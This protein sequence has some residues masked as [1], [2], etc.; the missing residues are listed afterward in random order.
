MHLEVMRKIT[1]T[2]VNLYRNRSRVATKSGT[3][4]SGLTTH[5][6]NKN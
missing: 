1:V 5:P 6:E 3:G 2:S 4:V